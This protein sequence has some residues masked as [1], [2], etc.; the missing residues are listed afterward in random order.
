MTAH[1]HL[2]ALMSKRLLEMKIIKKKL[3]QINFYVKRKI[4]MKHK[5]YCLTANIVRFLILCR[6]KRFV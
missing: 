2:C 4:E 5:Y 6:S 3:E 1:K